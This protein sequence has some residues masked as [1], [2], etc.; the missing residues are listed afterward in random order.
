MEAVESFLVCGLGSR[1]CGI[2]YYCTMHHTPD[3]QKNKSFTRS[4]K[5]CPLDQFSLLIT[6]MV[7]D[8]AGDQYS[9]MIFL[10]GSDKTNER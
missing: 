6:N 4:S 1:E 5:T 3:V 9:C 7:S 8:F 10:L 2:L